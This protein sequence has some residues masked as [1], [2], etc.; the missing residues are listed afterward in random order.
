MLVLV[1]NNLLSV[2]E[3]CV[4]VVN[5]INNIDEIF[6]FLVNFNFIKIFLDYKRLVFSSCGLNIKFNYEIDRV[7]FSRWTTL[8]M[9][10]Y[11]TTATFR[12]L[13]L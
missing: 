10:I 12:T 4:S 11:I 7:F 8:R 1:R 5:Y 3:K 13:I 9:V 2:Y 6:N